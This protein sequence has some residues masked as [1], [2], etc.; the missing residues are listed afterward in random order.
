MSRIRKPSP[1]SPSEN[2]LRF[3]F[4]VREGELGVAETLWYSSPEEL[5]ICC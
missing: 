5:Q 3:Y 1:D 2:Q 4:I